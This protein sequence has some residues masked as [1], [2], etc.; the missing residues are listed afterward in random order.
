[1]RGIESF[2]K[3]A[4]KAEIAVDWGQVGGGFGIDYNRE[5]SVERRSQDVSYSTRCSTI[6]GDPA[7]P[8]PCISQSDTESNAE[9]VEGRLQ[10]FWTPQDLTTGHSVFSL[11]LKDMSGVFGHMG[12]QNYSSA[13]KK[14]V[15]YHMCKPP[16]FKWLV[17]GQEHTCKC[18]LDC[19]NGGVLDVEKC[20]CQCPSDDY[21][22]W[23]GSDC[24]DPW[25]SCQMGV[26]SGNKAAARQ[27][28]VDN[29]CASPLW[30]ATCHSTEVCCLTPISGKCCPFGYS[31]DC[32]A[33]SCECVAPAQIAENSTNT[34]LA[35]QSQ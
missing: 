33:D 35:P 17:V 23:T 22:G 31:C 16:N 10:E 21:H 32:D 2:L 1:M 24:S 20:V 25:G 9:V 26:N 34:S 19:K 29:V 30:S 5:D 14:A 27:C 8:S 12:Y 3:D 28:P 11:Y 6:G 4:V 15:E 18:D 13:M 7:A